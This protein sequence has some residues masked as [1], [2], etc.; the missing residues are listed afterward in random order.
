MGSAVP[1]VRVS[2]DGIDHRRR[3]AGLHAA[4]VLVD[5]RRGRGL[6][7]ERGIDERVTPIGRLTADDSGEVRRERTHRRG[8]IVGVAEHLPREEVV[9][10]WYLQE[11]EREVVLLEPDVGCERQSGHTEEIV[12]EHRVRRISSEAGA[13]LVPHAVV[14]TSM[15]VTG[16][17]GLSVA[18]RLHVPKEGFAQ[19]DRDRL[20]ARFEK[21][22]QVRDGRD[23]Y[24][25]E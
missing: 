21:I 3:I 19:P 24:R 10:V 1:E 5:L 15:K 23:R 13:Q 11:M 9:L 17:T 20:S 12:P 14:G 7:V 18:A 16:A 22:G 4:H 8:H 2:E 6:H 25:G